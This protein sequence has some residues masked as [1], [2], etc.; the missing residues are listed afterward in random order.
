MDNRV[1]R[2]AVPLYIKLEA[3][4]EYKNAPKGTKG[5][6]L[7]K[8]K[9]FFKD[10]RTLRRHAKRTTEYEHSIAQG[11][12]GCRVRGGGMRGI[13]PPIFKKAL[14]NLIEE[15]RNEG[16]AVS[17]PWLRRKA[18]NL[19]K[20]MENELSLEITSPNAL[21]KLMNFKFENW[22]LSRFI[23]KSG[24]SIRQRTHTGVNPPEHYNQI[25]QE[26]LQRLKNKLLDLGIEEDDFHKV[27]LNLDET[28]IQIADSYKRTIDKKGKKT[29]HIKSGRKNKDRVTVL[30]LCSSQGK[31][32]S[33]MVIF[34]G[35]KD[36]RIHK[37]MKLLQKKYNGRVLI[38]V[39]AKAW[40]TT[41]L[42][43]CFLKEVFKNRCPGAL[44]FGPQPKL[45]LTMDNFSAHTNEGPA[46]LM[47]E[48]KIHPI[49]FPPNCTGY[50]QPLDVGV[51][52]SFKASFMDKLAEFLISTNDGEDPTREMI[53]DW[54]VLAWRELDSQIICNSFRHC[55]FNPNGV[56]VDIM[57]DGLKKMLDEDPI[58]AMKN[59]LERLQ[60][61]ENA[62][63]EEVEID[64]CSSD[65]TSGI[66]ELEEIEIV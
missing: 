65:D 17:F 33:P 51:N 19:V 4:L 52:K 15:A 58:E 30:L 10:E 27:L 20:K 59:S 53:V 35:K 40:M 12:K 13:V 47:E 36:A 44:S 48:L 26:F 6:V 60:L 39:N 63:V 38:E 62:G 8:Y 64:I 14:T 50:I 37:S 29:I 34:K 25:I 5:S 24:F 23:R 7:E 54:I 42:F 2:K 49:F 9:H 56:A 11:N 41:E 1:K 22:W 3:G 46:K 57:P 28:G 32:Y 43:C 31:K 16:T 21:E 55:L 66:D 45:V 61:T 18:I